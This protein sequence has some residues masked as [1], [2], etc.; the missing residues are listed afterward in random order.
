MKATRGTIAVTIFAIALAGAAATAQQA[1]TPTPETPR[2]TAGNPT[3]LPS[4]SSLPSPP[5]TQPTTNANAPEISTQEE[6]STTFK[7]KVNLVD[8]RVVV[9]DAQGNAMGNLR[10]ED[11]QLTDNGK[12]QVISKFSVEQAAA[13]PAAKPANSG[14]PIEDAAPKLPDRYVGYLFDDIHLQFGDLAQV[15]NAV[16]RN[17][18]GLQS[19]DRVAIFT[20]SG[21]TQLEFT[22][23][24]DKLRGTL[25]SI[26]PHPIAGSGVQE[27]PDVSYYMA[28]QIQNRHDDRALGV[29]TQDALDCA[30]G[31]D[32]TK[33]ATAQQLARSAAMRKLSL[34]DH[35]TQ[36]SLGSLKDAVRSVAAM[37]G[38]RSLILVSPGFIDP[39]QMT[40]QMEIAD[41]AL[42]SGVIINALDARG[43]Y[44]GM[45][46][47]TSRSPSHNTAGIMVQYEHDEASADADVLSELA[48]ATGGTFINDS[49]ELDGGLRRLSTPP[50][51]SYLL[52]FS[53]QDLKFDGR[54]HKLKV[55]VKEQKLNIQARKGYYAP[56]QA[57]SASEQAKQQIQDEVFSQEELRELP[58]ELHTQFFKVSDDSARLSVVVRLEVRHLHYRKAEGRNNNGLT[59]VSAVFDRNGNFVTG[60][61]KTLQMRWKDETLN[62]KLASGVTLKSSFDVKP[63]S[64]LVRLVVRDEDG[65]LAAQNGAIEI[66]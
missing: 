39:D 47:A 42:H 30:F 10:K 65:Q 12:P 17:L 61:Q 64:Y 1:T 34:G 37:P 59:V 6:T 24:R 7:V 48:Y 29:I 53:P 66:P 46:D 55:T 44:T 28:D 62:S 52:A 14:M 21:Q 41:R 16:K 50:E 3:T 15:R 58:V 63:G 33:L 25:D 22:D 36:V 38:Q 2:T 45:P 32:P 26:R 49:N 20:T 31:G 60:S 4:Q 19:T 9:R 27:C 35:E 8:V 51:Y 11:F 23:D 40:E 43:L 54:F 57:A 18:Q 5:A 56:K 13:R